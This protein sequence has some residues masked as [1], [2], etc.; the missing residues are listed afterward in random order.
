MVATPSSSNKASSRVI[1][2]ATASFSTQ[3]ER[4]PTHFCD[5]PSCLSILFHE[6][7]ACAPATESTY[8]DLL[9][10]IF[11]TLPSIDTMDES[12]LELYHPEISSEP[13]FKPL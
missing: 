8:E 2:I 6:W 3:G 12:T 5:C 10:S 13:T 7:G 1:D 4:N 9:D 11:A